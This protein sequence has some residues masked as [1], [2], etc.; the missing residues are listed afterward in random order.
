[1][2]LSAVNATQQLVEE[3][4]RVNEILAQVFVSV[5]AAVAVIDVD[6][7]LLMTNPAFDRMLGVAPGELAGQTSLE[8]VDPAFRPAAKAA[9]VRQLADNRDYTLPI[10]ALR[11]DGSS[12]DA[13]ITSV[14]IRS[15]QRQRYRIMTVREMNPPTRA[16]EEVRLAGKIKLIGLDAVKARLGE[17]WPELAARALSTAEHVIRQRLGPG[18]TFSRTAEED[19]VICFSGLDEQE[20]AFRA[21][22]I[23]REI[24]H[25]L[26][27]AGDDPEAAHVAAVTAPITVPADGTPRALT[28]MLADKLEARIV[29]VQERAR[30]ALES[31]ISEMSLEADPVYG[32]AGKLRLASYVRFSRVVG[33]RLYAAAAA[34][35]AGEAAKIDLD[36]FLLRLS[37]EHAK[38]QALRG[39]VSPMLVTVSFEAFTT[40]A[41]TD[42]YLDACRKVDPRLRQRLV[43]LLANLPPGMPES[44]IAD[45]VRQLSPL[46][47]AVGREISDLEVE[48]VESGLAPG[49]IVAIAE[50]ASYAISAPTGVQLTRFLARL[51]A[52][53]CKLLVRGLT[54]WSDA[55]RL[56]GLGV[57]LVT[58]DQD[59]SSARQGQ[60][61]EAPELAAPA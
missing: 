39:V 41:A 7:R 53:R 59:Q 46:C 29:E 33:S 54:N 28:D 31:A 43:L 52:K 14:M 25:R 55:E 18:E 15:M 5:H 48:R 57:D 2:T 10:R 30:Q 34:M 36:A 44:R 19:F 8:L 1:M 20:A 50:W 61:A 35:P 37:E 58:V 12:F 45:C 4:A 26:I 56:R 49:S 38:D 27:G 42:R 23:G 6:G 40:R 47:M 22:M 3:Q 24:Q 9:R 21:A 11:R 16:L 17:R 32:R 51:H 13:E 60:W